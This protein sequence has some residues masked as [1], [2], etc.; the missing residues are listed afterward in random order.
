MEFF[1]DRTSTGA[2]EDVGAD[3][4]SKEH[5]TGT[6]NPVLSWTIFA[7]AV[8]LSYANSLSLSILSVIVP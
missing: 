3:S 4:S 5:F 2:V 6:D 7:L 8:A 1:Q